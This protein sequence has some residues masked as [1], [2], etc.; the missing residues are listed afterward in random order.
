MD[1]L[2][3]DK[4][5]WLVF[6]IV[7]LFGGCFCVI[8]VA[9]G[10][11]E[12]SNQKN[13]QQSALEGKK[14]ELQ[15]L[16]NSLKAKEVQEVKKTTSTSGKIIYEVPGQQFTAEA[17]FGIMFENLLSNISNSGVRIRSIRY[18]YN[19]ADDRIISATRESGG[20]YNVCE[21]SF[22]AV[23]NY[24]QFQNFFKSL[25]KEKYLSNIYEMYIEPYDKDKSILINRFKVRLYTKT[26]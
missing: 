11:L 20:G 19:P 9:Q 13:E 17:S 4:I 10:Y 14:Q 2:I 21:L 26:I 25:A 1:K 8:Q 23:G 7:I 22:V 5:L 6:V 15:N 3:K 16:E 12:Q 18:N 24:A